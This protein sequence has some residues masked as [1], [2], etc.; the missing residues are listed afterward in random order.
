MFQVDVEL[1]RWG[2]G[3]WK[4]NVFTTKSAKACSHVLLLF[5]SG[6]EAFLGVKNCPIKKVS[7]VGD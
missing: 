3:G 7:R 4:N 6:V 2:D 5:R 1:R